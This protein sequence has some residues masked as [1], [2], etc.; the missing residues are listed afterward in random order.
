MPSELRVS[1]LTTPIG[2]FR[3]LFGDRTVRAVSLLERGVPEREVPADAVVVR[4]APPPGSAPAQ[5][6]EYFRGTRSVFDLGVPEDLGSH[7]DRDIWTE[8]L[9][10]PAGRT[11]GYGEL[12]RR[13]GHPGAAR[14]VG[15]AM[16]RNP[17]PIIVPCHRVVGE[18]R[19][20][21]GYG[22]GLWRKRWLLEHEGAWPLREG[23][24]YGPS[25]RRQRT[26]DGRERRGASSAAGPRAGPARSAV[27]DA[28]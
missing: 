22:L 15:G 24:I 11:I 20:L 18:D 28:P 2:Q 19:A 25:D 21:V 6:T 26:L 8:L 16:R 1:R 12:A 9:G 10:V 14:A 13:A 7:F 27:A 23:T 3:V 4:G 5:L 17:I